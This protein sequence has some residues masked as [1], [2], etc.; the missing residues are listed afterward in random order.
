MSL[1]PNNFTERKVIMEGQ[2]CLKSL[3]D[4]CSMFSHEEH[5]ETEA[6][7]CPFVQEEYSPNE[8]LEGFYIPSFQRGYRWTSLEV[9]QL[10]QDLVDFHK[11]SKEIIPDWYCLQPLVVV[12]GKEAKNENRWVVIDGQQRLTTLFLI[13][14][15]LRGNPGY[16]IEYETRAGSGDFLKG[17]FLKNIKDSEAEG[18]ADY[19]YILEAWKTIQPLIPS[20]QEEKE[21][22]CETILN[23]A[24]VIWYETTGNP[25]EEFSRLNSGKIS[26]SNAELMKALLLKGTLRDGKRELSQL[27]AAQE[28]DMMEHSLRDDDFWCFIN[29]E[30]NHKRFDATRIDFLFEMVL[31]MQG[32]DNK[33][34][35]AYNDRFKER[36]EEKGQQYGELRDKLEKNQYFIFGVFQEYCK[37]PSGAIEV[38]K[39]VQGVFRRIHSWYSDRTLFHCIGYLMN[40][41]GRKP[42]EKLDALA[43]WLCEAELKSKTD[44]LKLFNKQIRESIDKPLCSL[45]Y[46]QD[47]DA[48]NDV[49]LLFNIAIIMGRRQEKSR[50]PFREHKTAKWT[51]EHIHAKQERSLKIEDMKVIAHLLG[52][53]KVPEESE[54]GYSKAINDK[55]KS[56]GAVDQNGESVTQIS[57]KKEDGWKLIDTKETHGIENLALLG[58][59][60][61]AAFN[62]SL[63][64]EKRAILARWLMG[65][66]GSMSTEGKQSGGEKTDFEATIKGTEFS[67]VME[68]FKK[69]EFVPPATI[70][71]FFKQFSPEIDYPFLWT[72]NDANNY[73]NAIVATLCSTFNFDESKLRGDYPEKKEV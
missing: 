20:G 24:K 65:D 14:K 13:I 23:R 63:Y 73:I 53:D 72:E 28:W 32:K 1:C 27:E 46:G 25:Y 47:N 4:I 39:D 55:F 22:L 57:D 60:A 59:R 35:K 69:V 31:R 45:Y 16:P 44:M 41:K 66:Y 5:V 49:L 56:S 67:N 8:N 17:D 12:R 21:S 61:N 71:A 29:A 6:N 15:A 18:N 42:E 64:L 30:P 40:R 43:G 51:L 62:N 26:L 10:V 52:I 37:N 54:D 2:L 11:G 48:L 38:W 9:E 70:M 34:I 33:Y 7:N 58:H 19:H 36:V 68:E 50:Y 3:N